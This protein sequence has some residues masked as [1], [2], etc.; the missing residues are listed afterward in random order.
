MDN[1]LFGDFKTM[2]LFFNIYCFD[3][4]SKFYFKN[5]YYITYKLLQGIYRIKKLFGW[6]RT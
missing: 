1:L 3:N 5:E 2:R 6:P 4:Y